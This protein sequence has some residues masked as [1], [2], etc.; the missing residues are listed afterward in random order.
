M[1]LLQINMLPFYRLRK[2]GWSGDSRMG[3]WMGRGTTIDWLQRED[4][5]WQKTQPNTREQQNKAKMTE[6][7]WT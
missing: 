1:P 4:Y 7:A 2:W 6:V 3:G 5:K